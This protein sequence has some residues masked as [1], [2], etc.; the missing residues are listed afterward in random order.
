MGKTTST[1]GAVLLWEGGSDITLDPSG[2]VAPGVVG[3]T[4]RPARSIAMRLDR[5][6]GSFSVVLLDGAGGP[7]L[8]LGP[9]GEEDIVAEWRTLGAATGLPLKLQLPNGAVIEPYPQIGR[10]LLGPSRQRRRHGLLTHRRP[11]F[12]TRRK[13]GRFPLRPQVHREAEIAGETR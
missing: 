3:A 10:V 8:A 5:E 12:L 9:F 6:T 2:L 7:L 1:V 11:R 4:G 13:T